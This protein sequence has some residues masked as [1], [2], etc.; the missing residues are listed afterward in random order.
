MDIQN[1]TVMD[2]LLYVWISDPPKQGQGGVHK[3][4]GK[5]AA[6]NV[7]RDISSKQDNNYFS[8]R[9]FPRATTTLQVRCAKEKQSFANVT[10]WFENIYR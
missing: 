7:Q 10:T 6:A 8:K 2:D 5:C 4:S 3:H 1:K 9:G